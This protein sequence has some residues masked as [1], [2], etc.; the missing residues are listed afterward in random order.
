MG[1]LGLIQKDI[2]EAL[3]LSPNTVTRAIATTKPSDSRPKIAAYL[4]RLERERDG[5][6]S[7]PGQQPRKLDQLVGDSRL[8]DVRIEYIG[9]GKVQRLVALLV[10]SDL[11]REDVEREV[12]EWRKGHGDT[13]R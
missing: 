8:V 1:A 6:G 12:R 4:S 7:Q 10:D 5:S 13:S 11:S 3:A 2:C 9:D